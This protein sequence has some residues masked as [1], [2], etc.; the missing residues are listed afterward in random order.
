MGKIEKSE[1]VGY[2]VGEKIYCTECIGKQNIDFKEEDI[3]TKDDRD[4]SD[5]DYFCD[6][7]KS[8]L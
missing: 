6:E 4:D 3:I 5:H 7:C 1:I 8:R 2:E